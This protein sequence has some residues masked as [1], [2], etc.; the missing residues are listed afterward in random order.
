[1][2]L[3]RNGHPWVSGRI[4]GDT[5]PMANPIVRRTIAPILFRGVF[6]RL[7]TV[8]TPIGRK[9]RQVHLE[10][11]AADC[12]RG[13]DLRAAGVRRV[14]RTEGVS[15]QTD[16]GRRHGARRDERGVVHR[17]RHRSVVAPAHGVRPGRRANPVARVVA[18][19][20]GLYFVGTHSSMR[21][22][23]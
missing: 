16:D 5:V 18:G 11:Y 2:D 21:R 15:E 6:H 9:A 1:M 23:P 13:S 8:D 7:L 12:T 4:R 17:I 10:G 19:E 22:R 3:V 20:P 14:G